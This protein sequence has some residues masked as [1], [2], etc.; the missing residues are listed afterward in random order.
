MGAYD[1]FSMAPPGSVNPVAG[2]CHARG[3]NA[4]LPP[5]W[6]IYLLVEDLE[7]SLAACRA[8]G[9]QVLVGPKSMGPGSA[10][11]VI[12]DPAGAVAA[13]YQMGDQDSSSL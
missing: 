9:G 2:I 13:L 1:D 3:D 6:L 10:F 11:A 8:G 4:D 12:R 7:K 5:V